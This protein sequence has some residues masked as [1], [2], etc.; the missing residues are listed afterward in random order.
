M[1]GVKDLVEGMRTNTPAESRAGGKGAAYVK[2]EGVK[3]A[4][5]DP[6][7]ARWLTERLAGRAA[8][9][10]PKLAE[11]VPLDG[12]RRL[13]DVGGG[14]GIFSFAYLQK[15]PGL[16]A[17]IVELPMVAREAA[18]YASRYGVGDRVTCVI[19]NMFTEPLP[20]GADAILL[21]N[22][23]HDWD[24]DKSRRLVKK[25]ADALLPGGKLIIHDVLLNDQLDG[26]KT[27]A[28]YSVI[29]FYLT[30]GRAYSAL[31]YREWLLDAGLVPLDPVKTLVNC[32]A[33]T[34][35][36]PML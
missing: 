28:I 20:Q 14:T 27:I 34:A 21:S 31:E 17:E 4:M 9:T 30:E 35:V 29:L 19:K 33:V 2:S 24:V 12:A 5:D 18:N 25:C 15:Y 32:W 13:V 23:L 8:I 1:R 26:P 10:A 22:V 11:L 16:R 3:S 6:K 36:K 7:D